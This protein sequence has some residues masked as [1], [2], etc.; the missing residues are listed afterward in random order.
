[1]AYT[2]LNNLGLKVHT[3]K[4]MIILLEENGLNQLMVNI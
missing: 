1:M 3:K 2:T 4:N